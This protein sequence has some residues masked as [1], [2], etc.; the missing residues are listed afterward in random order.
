MKV[1][2]IKKWELA[3]VFIRGK[4]EEKLLSALRDYFFLTGT[5]QYLRTNVE[6]DSLQK[7]MPEGSGLY[8]KGFL[9]RKL[10]TYVYH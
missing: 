10:G 9:A 3:G 2:P 5:P 8:S 1:S 4:S 7:I 6:L